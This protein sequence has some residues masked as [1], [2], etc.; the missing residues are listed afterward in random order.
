MRNAN[1][2]ECLW[3][4]LRESTEGPTVTLEVPRDVADQLLNMLATS[5]EVDDDGDDMGMDMEP[6]D[7]DFGGPPDGDEDDL[8]FSAGSESPDFGDDD[9]EEDDDD[10]SDDDES[11]DDDDDDDEKDESAIPSRSPRTQT[12]LGERRRFQSR[13]W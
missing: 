12:A 13:R 4:Q 2:W 11:G 3:E 10:D 8:G 1:A 6:D 9:D 5:L 7:D